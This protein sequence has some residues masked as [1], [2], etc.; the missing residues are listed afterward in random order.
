MTAGTS[1]LL[2]ALGGGVAGISALARDNDD[3]QT[4][5]ALGEDGVAAPPGD[6]VDSSRPGGGAGQSSGTTDPAAGLGR[7][8]E[9]GSVGGLGSAGGGSGSGLGSAGGTGSANDPRDGRGNA[10]VGPPAVRGRTAPTQAYPPRNSDKA[11]RTAT[12]APRR[13]APKPR[14]SRPPARRPVVTTGGQ[15]RTRVIP[16]ST[17]VVN[18]PARLVGFKLVRAPGSAGVETLRYLVTF[19]N[20]KPTARRLVG[21]TI[22]RPA[23]PRVIVV[24]T[25]SVQ[26]CSAGVEGC[27]P[28]GREAPCP[29]ES[30]GAPRPYETTRP[31]AHKP[32]PSATPRK[33]SRSATPRKPGPSATP[34]KPGP[35]TKTPKSGVRPSP[36][37][38]GAVGGAGNP[39][40][41]P[42][43]RV[44]N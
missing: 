17:R 30:R 2:I 5:T 15:T 10:T 13:P 26:P 7:I 27:V 24:G 33:L 16:F 14:R 25:G 44:P 29:D 34:R 41:V 37:R 35:S 6:A 4:V 38:S 39:V 3:A 36:S 19:T 18:D 9:P 8:A 21:R 31:G 23:Q 12:R 28:T 42:A 11:D 1:A 43:C 32:S 40:E 22:T 20:G